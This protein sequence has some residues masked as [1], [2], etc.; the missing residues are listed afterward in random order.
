MPMEEYED[1]FT[2]AMAFP[3]VKKRWYVFFSRSGY[4]QPVRERAQREGAVLLQIPDLYSLD[5]T[6]WRNDEK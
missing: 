6:A 1:L 2:A 5:S 4:T 3:Q